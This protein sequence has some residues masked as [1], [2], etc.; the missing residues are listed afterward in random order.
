MAPEVTIVWPE[1]VETPVETDEITVMP[2][3]VE[4]DVE[5]EVEVEVT[6]SVLKEVFVAVEVLVDWA[7]EDNWLMKLELWTGHPETAGPQTTIVV[8]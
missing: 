4:V 6:V 7:K 5:V 3:W 2:D 1:P 8:Q